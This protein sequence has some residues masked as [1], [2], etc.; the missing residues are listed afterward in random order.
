MMRITI[1]TPTL[2]PIINLQHKVWCK[3]FVSRHDILYWDRKLGHMV[4]GSPKMVVELHM[5]TNRW[6]L[7]ACK[8]CMWKLTLW[9]ACLCIILANIYLWVL[10]CI[11][12]PVVQRLTQSKGCSRSREWDRHWSPHSST[13]CRTALR[14]WDT[15]SR[16]LHTCCHPPHS[17]LALSYN[18]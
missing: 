10:D 16:Y 6:L 12:N 5:Y 15:G 4:I 7:Q 18:I 17:R 14:P 9:C 11:L 2:M 1:G 8:V 3:K 13:S